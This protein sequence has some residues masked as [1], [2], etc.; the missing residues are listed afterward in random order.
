[1]VPTETTMKKKETKLTRLSK[2]CNELDYDIF[3]NFFS[4]Y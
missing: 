1:M 2:L 4:T 3:D